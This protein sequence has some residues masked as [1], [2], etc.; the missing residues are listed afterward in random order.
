MT[1]YPEDEVFINEVM[2]EVRRR[3]DGVFMPALLIEGGQPGGAVCLNLAL[4]RDALV[5]WLNKPVDIDIKAEDHT[6]VATTS[7]IWKTTTIL[8]SPISDTSAKEVVDSLYA[9]LA[10]HR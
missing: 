8:S 6:V 7:S 4:G 3:K 5:A 1:Q 10:K 9:Y 2:L